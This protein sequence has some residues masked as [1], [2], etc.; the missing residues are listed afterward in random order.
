MIQ[1]VIQAT[2]Q[3]AMPAVIQF[4]TTLNHGLKKP[5]KIVFTAFALL[6]IVFITGSCGQKTTGT[7]GLSIGI[8]PQQAYLL[9]GSAPNCLD[10]SAYKKA[11][12]S[13]TT[14]GPTEGTSVSPLRVSFPKFYL[15]WTQKIALYVA[16]IRFTITS[17][18]ITGGKFQ[19]DIA[20]AELS[21]LLGSSSNSFADQSK[22]VNS[23]D[24]AVSLTAS[25]T[26]HSDDPARDCLA[27]KNV[28]TSQP[29]TAITA[30]YSQFYSACGL[31]VGGI[32]L[33][34][35]NSA[36]QFTAPFTLK[37]VGYSV[38]SGGNQAPVS[39]MISGTVIYTGTN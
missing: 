38:D 30:I 11:I 31:D 16:Y 27:N 34:T 22:L 23:V 7:D 35:P 33:T 12:L 9:P 18:A 32:G 1:V 4:Q 20:G 36:T 37:L 2:I 6:S 21:A 17:S 25:G 10:V 39:T 8:Q 29:C 5:L 19:Y 24:L 3:A 14:A 26:I 28:L 15:T 13:S